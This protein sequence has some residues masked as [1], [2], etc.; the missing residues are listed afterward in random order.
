MTNLYF[1]L[2]PLSALLYQ[3]IS[4]VFNETSQLFSQNFLSQLS[5]FII[6]T[7]QIL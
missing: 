1:F 6:I 2:Y 7:I 5:H 3:S 4:Y